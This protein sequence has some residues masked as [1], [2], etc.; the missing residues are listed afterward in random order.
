VTGGATRPLQDVRVV[1]MALNVP[2]PLAVQRLAAE[3]AHVVKIEPPFGDPLEEL[4]P[5]WYA[6]MHRDVRVERVDLK[7]EEGRAR[8]KILLDDADVFVSS[9]RPSSLAR[10]GLDSTSLRAIRWVNIVGD[11]AEPDVAGHDLTDQ[12]RAGLLGEAMPRS[13]FA[14]VMGSERTVS[15]VLTV[16]R[17]PAG[18]HA[19]I[20]LYDSLTPLL[21]PLKHGMTTA[22]GV[23]GGGLPAYGIYRARNGWCAIAALEPQFRARLYQELDLEPEAPL[24]DAMLARTAD[25]WE[26]WA[27]ERDLPIAAVRSPSRDY[28]GHENT[29]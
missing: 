18:A 21:A 9:Q 28:G 3:G 8:L 26:E 20:G 4:S 12:A 11:R 2:G 23:L 14:D 7:R 16:L 6:E 25:E 29:K 1:T 13:L 15:A 22:G 5:A 27:R 10:L 19:E 24:D 17:Q